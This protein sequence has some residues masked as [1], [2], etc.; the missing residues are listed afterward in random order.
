MRDS[1]NVKGG[2]AEEFRYEVTFTTDK[3]PE[4]VT[5]TGTEEIDGWTYFWDVSGGW[6]L[7]VQSGVIHHITRGTPTTT[8]QARG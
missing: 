4:V 8:S 5:A 1:L 7:K 2:R 3:T 6:G